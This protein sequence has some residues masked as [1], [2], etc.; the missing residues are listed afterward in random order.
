MVLPQVLTKGLILENDSIFHFNRIFDT[1]EQFRTHNINYYQMNYSFQQSGRVINAVYGPLFSYLLGLVLFVCGSWLKFQL[2]TLC[3][4]YFVSGVGMYLLTKR[5]KASDI[6]GICCSVLFMGSPYIVAWGLS[7]QFTAW[8]MM[9]M[10]YVLLNGIDMVDPERHVNVL[11]LSISVAIVI[12]VHMLSSLFVVFALVPF[13]V[14]GL[15]QK[16]NRIQLVLRV[17]LSAVIA[18]SLSLNVIAMM[19]E[20]FRGNHIVSP[21]PNVNMQDYTGVLSLSIPSISAVNLGFILTIVSVVQWLLFLCLPKNRIISTIT[22]TGAVF[23]IMSS[24]LIPWQ[25]L[26]RSVPMLMTFLQFPVRLLSVS[27]TL[28]L[29]GLAYELTILTKRKRIFVAFSNAFIITCAACSLAIGCWQLYSPGLFIEFQKSSA[30][31]RF[32]RDCAALVFHP[33]GAPIC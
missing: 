26:S 33:L 12:Q 21:F 15:C 3:G 25:A 2:V 13:F 10:P 20:L 6:A 8:G 24:P 22:V 1:Y 31:P 28:T 9:L 7:Q 23:F 11:L 32:T 18:V 5:V 30:I 14:V 27:I 19:L 17:V 4:L 29:A 16:Q